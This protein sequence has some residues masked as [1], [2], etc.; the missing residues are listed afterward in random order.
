MLAI[1]RSLAGGEGLSSIAEVGIMVR[2]GEVLESTRD[3]AEAAELYQRTIRSG[4][5]DPAVLFEYELDKVWT[6]RHHTCPRVKI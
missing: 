3:F 2:L 6:P 1:A 5:A 4:M